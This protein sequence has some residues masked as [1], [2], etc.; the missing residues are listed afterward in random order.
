MEISICI[1]KEF[2]LFFGVFR[3][4]RRAK[5]VF[6]YGWL[7]IIFWSFYRKKCLED[8]SM[9][10]RKSKKKECNTLTSRLRIFFLFQINE[11]EW[12]LVCLDG[13]EGVRSAKYGWNVSRCDAVW[14][15]DGWAVTGKRWRKG[16][17]QEKLLSLSEAR[18]ESDLFTEEETQ[19]NKLV[20]KQKPPLEGKPKEDSDGVLRRIFLLGDALS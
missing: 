13:W 3:E 14:C 5:R 20:I 10:K 6:F 12:C 7:R 19:M 9:Q 18:V 1:Q 8:R 2:F 16:S 15:M 4:L 17:E 11:L